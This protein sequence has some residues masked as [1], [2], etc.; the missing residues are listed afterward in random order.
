MEEEDAAESSRGSS[1]WRDVRNLQEQLGESGF[2][3]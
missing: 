2:P 1:V 3:R